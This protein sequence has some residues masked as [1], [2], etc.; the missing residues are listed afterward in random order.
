MLNLTPHT[1]NLKTADGIVSYPPSG[2]LAR[3]TEV[4]S[5]TGQDIEGVPVVTRGWGHVVGIP[6]DAQGI[7]VPCLVS[8]LVLGA[9]PIGTRN[10]YAPDTGETAIRNEK[11]QVVAVK[12]L[13]AV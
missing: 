7:P 10:V 5:S 11:G 2:M 9:L 6:R 8:S 12:R 1:I 4:Y 3:V 13:V